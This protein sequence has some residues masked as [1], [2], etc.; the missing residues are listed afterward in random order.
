MTS[1][2]H[3][4]FLRVMSGFLFACFALT[5]N[6]CPATLQSRS[7]KPAGFLKDYSQLKKGEKD[8]ALLV[9]INSDANFS[10]YKKIIID[11]I[12]IWRIE[13]SSLDKLSDEDR[14][15]LADYLHVAIT[16]KLSEDYIIVLDPGRDVMRLRVAITEGKG[17]RVVL[18]TLSNI[19]PPAIALSALKQI[20]T[21]TPA[22]VG[23]AGIE[24][25]V[26]DS[27]SNHRLGAFVDRRVGGKA[28]K[29]KFN[30][31]DDVQKAY[32]WWADRMKT[33]L[34]ELSKK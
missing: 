29:G 7:A 4:L 30:K 17:S 8:Q 25:E 9:Y 33:R 22:A 14:S 2:R 31:W 6:A 21:G 11:P 27:L 18:D 24:G 15:R 13:K 32:D 23:K 26:L 34:A 12:T 3:K 16:L 1:Y 5:L 19:L 20:A 28:F 10:N